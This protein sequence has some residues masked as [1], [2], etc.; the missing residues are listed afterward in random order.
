MKFIFIQCIGNYHYA[1]WGS[2][3]PKLGRASGSPFTS[4]RVLDRS[5]FDLEL[6]Q[7]FC[8]TWYFCSPN[9]ELTTWTELP[10]VFLMI[11]GNHDLDAK[12]ALSIQKCHCFQAL[13]MESARK[14]IFFKTYK[15]MPITLIHFK[16]PPHFPL[17]PYSHIASQV[18]EHIYLFALSYNIYKVISRLLYQ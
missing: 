6:F 3:C 10:W 4:L 17:L 9:L 11:I 2:N 15:F 1:Y 8:L 16:I 12:H 7:A 13:W 5:P 14:C 18:Y